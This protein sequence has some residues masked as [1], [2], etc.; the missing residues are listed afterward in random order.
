MK[1]IL[2][3]IIGF[4]G[5][6]TFAQ[7]NDVSV[8]G[9]GKGSP[10]FCVN[11]PV[12]YE[13]NFGKIVGF[14]SDGRYS[15]QYNGGTYHGQVSSNVNPQSL[16][17][18]TEGKCG[19][20]V[21]RFC[22]NANEPVFHEQYLGAIVGV[23]ANGDY[24]FKYYGGTYH[25]Q[26]SVG[27]KANK[28]YRGTKGKCGSTSPRFCVGEPTFY[29][30]HSGTIVGFN[31][32]EK[33]VFKYN[34]GTYHGQVSPNL[35][36][37]SLVKIKKS[38]YSGA[39]CEGVDATLSEIPS[40]VLNAYLS[41]AKV[42]TAERST[43]LTEISQYIVS[44]NQAESTLFARLVFAKIVKDSTAKI[45]QDNFAKSVQDDLNDL[46]KIGWKSIDQIEAKISTLDFAIRVL[47]AGVKL[48][49]SMPDAND[50]MNSFRTRLAAVVGV[51]K[52]SVKITTLQQIVT[53]MQPLL[54]DLMQ[55]PRHAA[56]GDV[57][58]EVAGWILK[59]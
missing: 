57:T 15:F 29:G 49:M 24:A 53:D 36:A 8:N 32:D 17:H 50:S 39:S 35:A 20:S 6:Q 1:T 38:G 48:R 28:I 4:L 9:C 10:R 52:L 46:E 27:L 58:Q 55:D 59:N 56:L 40:D 47:A 37:E 2:I 30:S 19:T 33:Y 44:Q 13:N 26:V 51:P 3:L 5:L 43:F 12:Y 21:P 25:G 23:G 16:Y 22:V 11:E 14:S 34:G 42:T 54:Q 18:A 31:A 7:S 41:L 45:V